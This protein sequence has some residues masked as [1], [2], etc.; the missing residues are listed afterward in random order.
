VCHRP[1]VTVLP[2]AATDADSVHTAQSTHITLSTLCAARPDVSAEFALLQV[3]M[4]TR[5]KVQMLLNKSGS[6]EQSSVEAKRT[7][8]AR[9]LASLPPSP[10]RDSKALS[11]P[12][13]VSVCFKRKL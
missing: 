13:N 10:S 8:P 12:S 9:S 4:R 7:D 11:L 3:H 2:T 6:D 5:D 1:R